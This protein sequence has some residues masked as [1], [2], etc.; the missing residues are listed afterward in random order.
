[1]SHQLTRH[2]PKI[3]ERFARQVTHHLD[4][5]SQ[6]LPNDIGERL[7]AARVQAIAKHRRVQVALE[8]KLAVS[9]GSLV[10]PGAQDGGLWN[11]LASF[12]P[13]IGL[14]LG[15]WVIDGMQDQQRASELAEVDSELL[16]DDLPLS[17][18]TDPGFLHFLRNN[19]R[20]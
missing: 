18:Y 9:N 8:G 12:L 2:A 13:L 16:A 1:M 14:V 11:R 19:R 17:A 20:D 6:N 10:L 15:L 4:E 7:K 3:E 5:I